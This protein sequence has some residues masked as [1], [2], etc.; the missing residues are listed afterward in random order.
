MITKEDIEK[1]EIALQGE[2]KKEALRALVTS[3][4][5]MVSGFNQYRNAVKD[6]E[7]HCDEYKAIAESNQKACVDLTQAIKHIYIALNNERDKLPTSL[8]QL[9]EELSKFVLS[10][11]AIKI[12]VMDHANK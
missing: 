5:A 8:L 2:N 4:E 10:G 11:A 1:F 6:L 7:N 3:I 12:G 9:T